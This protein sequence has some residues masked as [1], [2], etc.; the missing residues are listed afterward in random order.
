MIN[1]LVEYLGEREW[2]LL[3]NMVEY[4]DRVNKVVL[5]LVVNIIPP[6]LLLPHQKHSTTMTEFYF[7]NYHRVNMKWNHQHFLLFPNKSAFLP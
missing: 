4:L 6:L 3:Q 7:N 5:L 1:N 2:V